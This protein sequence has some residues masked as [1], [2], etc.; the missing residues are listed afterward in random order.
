MNNIAQIAN[1]YT[2][3]KSKQQADDKS[4]L[5]FIISIVTRGNLEILARKNKM[6]AGLNKK[7]SSA[8]VKADQLF[9]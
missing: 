7:L 5:Q 1:Q 6:K 2:M 4:L 9:D 3:T 8:K